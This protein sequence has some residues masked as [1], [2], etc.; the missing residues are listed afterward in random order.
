MKRIL[1][2][3][4][5]LAC[6]L[7]VSGCQSYA[8]DDDTMGTTSSVVNT[9]ENIPVTSVRFNG[10]PIDRTGGS[11]CC[12]DV[13]KTWHPGMTA[14]IEWEVDAH[15]EYN[16]GGAK[17]PPGNSPNYEEWYNIHKSQ[18]IHHSAV[19]PIARFTSVTELSVVFLPC[20]RVAA[21]PRCQNSCRLSV[22]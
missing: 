15:P 21:I 3:W 17:A 6:I 13:P 9:V 7:C 18:Y 16:L 19:V 5:A 20:N 22:N 11:T 10:N 8:A 1:K 2:I 12:V 14:T 4:A